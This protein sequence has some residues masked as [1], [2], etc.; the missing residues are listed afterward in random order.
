MVL[1]EVERDVQ[2]KV[3]RETVKRVPL[4]RDLQAA[5]E[6]ARCRYWTPS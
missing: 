4:D 5:M 2:G 6:W 3:V 1:R